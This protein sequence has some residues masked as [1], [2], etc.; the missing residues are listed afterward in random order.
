MKRRMTW[1]LAAMLTCAITLGGCGGGSTPQEPTAQEDAIVAEQDAANPDEQTEQANPAEKFVG[2]WKFAYLQEDG[3]TVIGNPE[4]LEETFGQTIDISVTFEEAGTGTITLGNETHDI[5]WEV[6]DAGDSVLVLTDDE[7]TVPSTF[8]YEDGELHTPTNDTTGVMTLTPD[9]KS[10]KVK[11]VSL[12]DAVDITSADELVGEW[13]LTGQ[14][15]GGLFITGET[16]KLLEYTNE[17]FASASFKDDGTCTLLGYDVTYS[18]GEN[19]ATIDTKGGSI[20]VKTMEGDLIIDLAPIS[21]DASGT[22]AYLRY[23][24]A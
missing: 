11:A 13:K 15:V 3:V 17:G 7:N 12:A 23:S 19:G 2:S 9:G 22:E 21:D 20:P 16:D 6:D 10:E 8:K 4:F 14:L 1:T 5:T 24:R 18:V